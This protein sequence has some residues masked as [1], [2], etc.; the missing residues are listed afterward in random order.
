MI[1]NSATA[2]LMIPIGVSLA[3]SD[4]I[5][6][7]PVN[8][9]YVAWRDYRGDIREIYVRR[10]REGQW[11]EVG[12]ASA[13]GGGISNNDGVSILPAIAIPLNAAPSTRDI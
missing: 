7:S 6:I 10:F 5:A 12:A 13:T 9:P 3:A 11:G 2:N 1:S 4:A 8:T